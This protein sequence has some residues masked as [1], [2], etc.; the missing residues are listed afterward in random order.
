VGV[1]AAGIRAP[2]LGSCARFLGAS[3]I[4]GS[5][6]TVSA[7]G[8]RDQPEHWHPA[9]TRT[10]VAEQPTGTAHCPRSLGGLGSESESGSSLVGQAAL[11]Q[12]FKLNSDAS[13]LHNGQPQCDSSCHFRKE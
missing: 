6:G 11:A 8:P 1:E 2:H 12:L 13:G 9:M 4:S 10:S 3:V 5:K 7:A